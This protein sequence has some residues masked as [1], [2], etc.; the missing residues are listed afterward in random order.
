M[1]RISEQKWV[2]KFV[3]RMHHIPVSE[4][5]TGVR[6]GIKADKKLFSLRQKHLHD[7]HSRRLLPRFICLLWKHKIEGGQSN[8][9]IKAS[10]KMLQ[11]RWDIKLKELSK[12]KTM[13]GDREAAYY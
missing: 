10:Q 13:V 6:A 7:Y 4:L 11:F 9:S 8:M 1:V 12:E 2:T 5:G 3:L